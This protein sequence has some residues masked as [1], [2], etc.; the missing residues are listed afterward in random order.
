MQP[1]YYGT[2]GKKHFMYD[3]GKNLLFAASATSTTRRTVCPA[4]YVS[5]VGLFDGSAPGADELRRTPV[6]GLVTGNQTPQC[7]P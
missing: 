2:I 5:A 4:K 1:D 6:C 3:V 7:T